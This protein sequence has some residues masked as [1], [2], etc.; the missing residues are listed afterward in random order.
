[1]SPPD[2]SLAAALR[3]WLPWLIA[4]G[5]CA[6]AALSGLRIYHLHSEADTLRTERELANVAARLAESRLQERTLL[7]EKIIADLQSAQR[8]N[9]D[10]A[11]LRSQLLASP[12]AHLPEARAAVLWDASRLH[13][14]IA[15]QGLPVIAEEFEYRLWL[16]SAPGTS[17]QTIAKFRSDSTG[18]AT[19][20]LTLSG[21]PGRSAK[22]F[23][24]VEARGT[25]SGAA[26]PIVLGSR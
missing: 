25:D 17:A 14:L 1:M 15:A 4:L 21:A 3:R 10:L 8:S 23:V 2:E 12:Q 19:A 13:G 22:F 24:S 26:G 9:A 16:E 6:L 20:P 5:A 7:A 11:R 18:A